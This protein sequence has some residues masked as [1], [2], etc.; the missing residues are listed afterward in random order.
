VPDLGPT[1]SPDGTRAAGRDTAQGVAG[2]IWLLDFTRGGVR[3][4][5]TFS[6]NSGTFPVWSPD[7]GRIAFSAG[8]NGDIYEKAASGA[9]EEKLLLKSPTI[10]VPTSWSRDGRF[11]LYFTIGSKTANDLWVLPL[12]GQQAGKPALLLGTEFVEELGS[13][14]PDGRWVAYL[15]TETGRYEIYVRPF[16]ADG[17]LFGDGKWQLSTGGAATDKPPRWRS[18]G[19]EIIF[20]APNGTIMA[21]DVNAGGSA[22]APGVPH[23]LFTPPANRGWDVTADGKRFLVQVQPG[24]QNT[25]PPITVVLNWAADL[26]R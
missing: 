5:L 15:S 23:P 26:K 2:D 7:G 1:L 13:F 14:S 17:P 24:Q 3:T 22:F 11:L 9:G 6:R 19:K 25:Q 20:T 16:V 18:D 10:K 4:R 8:S 12:E 21:V